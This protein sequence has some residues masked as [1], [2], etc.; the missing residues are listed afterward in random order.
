MKELLCNVVGNESLRNRLGLDVLQDKLPHAII[1]EGARGSGRRT[2]AKTLAA[3]LVCERKGE[4]GVALP[5]QD[6]LSCRKVFENKSPDVITI[7]RE[8]DKATLGIEPIRFLKSDVY[9]VPND[10]DRKVYV[11]DEADKMTQQA[12]NALLLT[13]E[14]PPSYVHIIL[15]CENS[16]VLLETIRSR[17]PIMRTERL[18][19]EQIDKYVSSVDRRAAQLKL[20]D[21]KRYAELLMASGGGI[22]PAL[23]YLDTNAFEPVYQRREFAIALVRAMI[24]DGRASSTIP[25]LTRFFKKGQREPATNHLLT[26]NDALRD[27]ILLKKSD[28]ASLCFFADRDEAIELSDCASIT[29]LFE[30]QSAVRT[31][32]DEISLRSANIR[33]SLTKMMVSSKIL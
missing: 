28:S 20:S 13:L 4:D 23:E 3:S 6:C 5:C 12:Q 17:A 14:E 21:P 32:I 9:T 8:K 27:L 33:L 2:L 30:L 25:L 18:S 1:I 16:S 22:G 19:T 11:I 15:I 7:R 26:V 31:A 29:F 10:S 24:K